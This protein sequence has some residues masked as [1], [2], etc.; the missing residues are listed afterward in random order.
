M[1]ATVAVVGASGHTGSFVIAEL[2]ARGHR[3]IAVGRDPTRLAAARWAHDDIPVRVASLDRLELERALAGAHVV[4]NC[5]GP[6]LDTADTVV[7]AALEVGAHYLDVT[8]EQASAA[9][10]LDRFGER[11]SDVGVTVSPAVGFFGGLADVLLTSLIDE[12]GGV[13]DIDTA[14]I[15]IALD[16]W[17]PTPGTRATGARNNVP[18]VTIRNG[19]LAPLTASPP[20]ATWTFVEPFGTQPV[21]AVAFSEVPLIARHLRVRHLDTFLNT[22]PLS[23][24]RDPA[25]PPPLPADDLGR[26]AQRFAVD[27]TAQG[28]STVRRVSATGTDIYAVTAPI[29]V[30]A[31]EQVVAGVEA[32]A[33]PVGAILNTKQ[34]LNALSDRSDHGEPPIRLVT[35]R[36]A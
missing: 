35:P 18:R 9:D 24:L 12:L 30:A 11:A 6:F 13:G 20:G 10:T 23:D 26:S 14:T 2:L 15:A 27:V 21:D 34:L 4:I 7:N 28:S 3:P 33:H 8:A 31:V 5:A 32:G 19:Q 29:V 25:T 22:A 1:G 36:P 16:S 17:H